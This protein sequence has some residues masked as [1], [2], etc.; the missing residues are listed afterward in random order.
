MSYV[1]YYVAIMAIT[2]VLPIPQDELHRILREHGVVSASVFGSFARGEAT[3]SSDL[4]LLVTLEPGGSAF[5]LVDLQ[6]ELERATRRTVDVVTILHP[7][8]KPYI[9]PDLAQIL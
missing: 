6:I 1:C 3:P 7:R 2:V 9:A 4:D 8:F 5:D